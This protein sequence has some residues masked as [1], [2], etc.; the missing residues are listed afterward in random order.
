MVMPR[1]TAI[2]K[3][4]AEIKAMLYSRR[5]RLARTNTSVQPRP[6]WGEI[7]LGELGGKIS[8]EINVGSI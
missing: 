7:E 3:L 5:T 8:P 4:L 2:A 1:L 6:F